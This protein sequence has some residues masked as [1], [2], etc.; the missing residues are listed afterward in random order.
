MRVSVAVIFNPRPFFRFRIPVSTASYSK[1]HKSPQNCSSERN[2]KIRFDFGFKIL[3]NYRNIRISRRHCFFFC[4]FRLLRIA[5]SEASDTQV[6]NSNRHF[7]IVKDKK[8]TF[9]K[10]RKNN[11]KNTNKRGKICIS[12]K[13]AKNR[14]GSIF[15]YHQIRSDSTKDANKVKSFWFLTFEQKFLVI[16]VI[17][18][19][20]GAMI[21]VKLKK[22][23]LL[24]HHTPNDVLWNTKIASVQHSHNHIEQF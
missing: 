24:N 8:K 19:R 11:I 1:M 18:I 23:F 21:K 12:S 4:N 20:N 9:S 5:D 13:N 6:W 16:Q 7:N 22:F 17:W 14:C 10:K 3:S 15:F 2:M